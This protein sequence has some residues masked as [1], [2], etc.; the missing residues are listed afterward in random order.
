MAYSIDSRTIQPGDIFIPIKGPKFDGHDFI[1]EVQ[2]KG[3]T[4][5][6]ADLAELAREQRKK[7]KIPIIGI[8]GSAGKTT[9]KDMLAAALSLKYKVYKSPENNNNEIGVPLAL[10][11]I[12]KDAEIAVLEL[13]MRGPGQIEYLA[14]IVQ[15]TH[16][17]IT[18]IGYTHLELLHTREAIAA[19]KSEIIRKGIKIFLNKQD[20][21]FN[22]LKE[23]AEAKDA[24]V[25]TF[26]YDSVL[27][28]NEN[29]VASVA[30]EFDL[31]TEQIKAGL[32]K[33]QASSHR[34]KI[35]NSQKFPGLTI[36]DDAYNSNPD[37]VKF[38]LTVL[39][40]KAGKNRKIAVLGDMKELG[41]E[42]KKL[43]KMVDTRGIELVITYGLLAENIKHQL[44]FPD[45]EKTRLI[46]ELKGLVRP[47][48]YILI[49]G[50]RSMKM[51][52]IIE[53]LI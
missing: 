36:I 19:A 21:F 38:A 2:K 6:D 27:L 12:P 53:A 8:T 7:L 15:P 37:A 47:G 49:K 51:E 11:N 18:N 5:L 28:A 13:A 25:Y 50:S 46:A 43:H 26:S 29:A 23:Q 41:P 44:S 9:V 42:E 48:D 30:R 33:F 32:E 35:I 14:E 45:T 17:L 34:L 52:E 39:K 16:A 31:T 4:V 20:D 1:P 40:E 22:Y 3:A 24:L 10:L